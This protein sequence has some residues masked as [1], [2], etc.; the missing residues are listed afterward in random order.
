MERNILEN[1]VEKGFS[2]Y[3]IADKLEC[4]QTNIRYWLNKFELTTKKNI[5]KN[6]TNSKVCPSC[7]ADKELKEFYSKRGKI[8]GSSYCKLCSKE[9][10]R[11]RARKFKLK[12]VNY[13]GGKC[14]KCG[15]D[16]YIGA[17]EFHHI[18]PKQKDFGMANVKQHSFNDK[19]KNELDK[20]IMVC[21]NCHKEIH[22]SMV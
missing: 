10:G 14:E 19:I 21:S 15:Y 12:C 9:E 16:K 13:K 4:S 1:L 6:I 8:G 5:T 20:C 22:G 18:D 7:N 17:L 11:E 3:Q 2:S